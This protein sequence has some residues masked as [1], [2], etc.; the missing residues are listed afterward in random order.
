MQRTFAIW[1]FA[2]KFLV[3]YWLLGKKFTYG[4]QVRT[5]QPPDAVTCSCQPYV[6]QAAASAAGAHP[7]SGPVTTAWTS[8]S[9]LI[10]MRGTLLMSRATTGHRSPISC[11]HPQGMTTERMAARKAKLASWL[12]QGLIRLGPTFIKIGQ[13]FSTRVDV[14]APEF[15]KVRVSATVQLT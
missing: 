11:H 12:R 13:Q 15:V 8:S 4:K 7:D 5:Q 1:S 14:L 6:P 2:F 9:E 3:R 10:Q